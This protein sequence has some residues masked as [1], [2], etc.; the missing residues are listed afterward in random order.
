MKLRNFNFPT[1]PNAKTFLKSISIDKIKLSPKSI[2][3]LKSMQIKN[4]D[5]I[6]DMSADKLEILSKK[7]GQSSKAALKKAGDFLMDN[8]KTLFGGTV[9]ATGMIIFETTNPALA[10]A[11]LLRAGFQEVIAPMTDELLDELGIYDLFLDF[12]NKW[13]WIMLIFIIVSIIF[14]LI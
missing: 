13:K 5:D 1:I 7:A 3:N 10:A 9:L 6:A 8:P 2:G 14:A 11:K 12:F 4:L